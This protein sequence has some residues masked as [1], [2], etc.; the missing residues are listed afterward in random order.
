MELERSSRGADAAEQAKSCVHVLAAS[1]A[2]LRFLGFVS[3]G[4]SSAGSERHG[5]GVGR[6]G[7]EAGKQR[8]RE[9]GRKARG[10]LTRWQRDSEAKSQGGG[11]G[12]GEREE[13]V[14]SRQQTK[15]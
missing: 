4:R 13:E 14:S 11:S 5:G 12:K 9:R 3:W 15:T 10:Q 2:W 1:R 6:G 7:R 8:G